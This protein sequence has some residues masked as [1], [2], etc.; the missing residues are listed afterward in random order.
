MLFNVTCMGSYRDIVVFLHCILIQNTFPYY[1]FLRFFLFVFLLFLFLLD[2]SQCIF[3]L[4]AS[5]FTHQM[6]AK[7]GSCL[8]SRLG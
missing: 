6:L 4:L 2:C 5:Q 8:K 1:I 7:V 3:F